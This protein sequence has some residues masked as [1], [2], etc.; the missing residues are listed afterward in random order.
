M[1]K[2]ILVIGSLGQLG[3]AIMNAPHDK[4]IE[5][6]GTNKTEC[7]ITNLEL[8]RQTFEKYKPTHVINCAAYLDTVG[9]ESNSGECFKL[10]AQGVYNLSIFCNQFDAELIQISSDMVFGGNQEIPFMEYDQFNPKNIYGLSKVASEQ[11][12]AKSKKHKIIR[13]NNL[14]GLIPSKAKGT[15]IHK[16]L[17]MLKDGNKVKVYNHHIITIS[18]AEDVAKALLFLLCISSKGNVYHL[19]N[20]GLTSWY[21]FTKEVISYFPEFIDKLIVRPESEEI[22]DNA[23][24]YRAKYCALKNTATLPLP[25]W[26]DA[27]RRFVKKQTII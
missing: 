15:F 16:I 20:E 5:L 1:N 22:I 18:Y 6:I 21:E 4:T 13:V 23:I 10:N 27:V 3:N 24:M 12:A 9:A 7:D 17:K 25:H 26:K 8:I 19:T 14:F 11:M 2:K